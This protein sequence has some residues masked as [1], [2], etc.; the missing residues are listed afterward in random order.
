[1]KLKKVL[2]VYKDSILEEHCKT[3]N[4]VRRILNEYD[5]KNSFIKRNELNKE[6]VFPR[7]IVEGPFF[8]ARLKEN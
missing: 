5:V 1:M 6:E 4:E 2:V 3:T 8:F 7:L